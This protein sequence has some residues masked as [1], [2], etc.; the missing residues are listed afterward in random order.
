MRVFQIFLGKSYIRNSS[1][2]CLESPSMGIEKVQGGPRDF[3][4]V[5]GVA[6][7]EGLGLANSTGASNSILITRPHL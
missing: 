1:L 5:V 2:L 7:K 6:N 4:E 3:E